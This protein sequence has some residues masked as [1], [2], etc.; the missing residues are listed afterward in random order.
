VS[1]LVERAG[2]D[3]AIVEDVVL[4]CTQQQREQAVDWDELDEER[5]ALFAVG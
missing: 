3:P 5:V 1:A 2:I 4:G